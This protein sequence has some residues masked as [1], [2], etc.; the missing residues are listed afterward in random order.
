VYAGNPA[1]TTTPL[2]SLNSGG[3]FVQPSSTREE[4]KMRKTIG[5]A[6]LLLALTC[7]TYAGEMGNDTPTPPPAHVAQEPT[8]NGIMQTEATDSLTQ[9]ALDLLAALPSLL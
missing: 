9:I 4:K 7:S 5:I 8:T 2:D 1:Y 6:A 3:Y